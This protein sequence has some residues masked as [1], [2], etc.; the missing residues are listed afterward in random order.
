MYNPKWRQGFDSI[1]EAVENLEKKVIKKEELTEEELE[2]LVFWGR[3]VAERKSNELD[4]WTRDVQTI[5]DI[6][7]Y[8]YA[9]DWREGL[10]EEQENF[11]WTQP[12]KVKKETKK[13]V[14]IVDT[15]VKVEE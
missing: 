3:H 12:Y 5:I 15:Y 13:V 4:R 11:F 9:I 8:L 6:D 10:T 1:E 2:G 7:G 14:T